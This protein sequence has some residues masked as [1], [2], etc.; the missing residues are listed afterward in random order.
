MGRAT[1][2]LL[3]GFDRLNNN[4]V[5]IATT[6]LFEKFDK[7]II[8]RFDS[9]VNFNQYTQTDLL[10]I[11]ETLF[12][13]YTSKFKINNKNTRL[14]KKI[15]KICPKLPYPGDLK[16]IIKTALAFSDPEDDSD[17]LRRFYES[18]IGDIPSNIV[19][20]QEQGFTIRE[21]EIFSGIS[22]SQVA[23]SLQVGNK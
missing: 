19:E 18:L 10:S 9:S 22:K 5:I 15:L 12:N 1:S 23:R 11:G 6:N 14:F 2:S 17:F 7:A 8:R 21:I 20:L 4:I 16:N 13:H 3:K